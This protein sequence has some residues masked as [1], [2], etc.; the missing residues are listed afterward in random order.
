MTHRVA[1]WR[2]PSDRLVSREQAGFTL[3]ELIVSIGL[4]ALAVGVMFAT[5]G[6]GQSGFRTQL[7][8][9][10][11]QQRLRVAVSMLSGDLLMAGAGPER[12][13]IRGAF[14]RL[15][16]PIRP[17]RRGLRAAE[18][19]LAFATDRITIVRG[20]Q[21]RAQAGL[22]Q[23]MHSPGDVVRLDARGQGC[24]PVGAC[25]FQAGMRAAIFDPRVVGAGYDLFTVDRVSRDA[26]GHLPFAFSRPYGRLMTE[27]MEI[28]QRVYYHDARGR[29]LVR[30]DG[31]RSEAVVV[32]GVVGLA[33]DYYVDPRPDGVRA[34]AP[35]E[36]SCVY[37]AGDPPRPR[38]ID[39]GGTALR[40]LT[41]AQLTDGPVCGQAPNRFD[42]DLLRLRKVRVTIRVQV[43]DESLRGSDPRDFTDPGA[44][45]QAVHHVPDYTMTFEVA[46]R[47]LNVGRRG[48]P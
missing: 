45:R 43:A 7:A 32:D 29:R 6:R 37:G 27:V 30:Y 19:D 33:F 18:G 38:L 14:A 3:V 9:G 22:A 16:P 13:G 15:L 20:A 4:T 26:L 48:R 46:P 28:E 5:I 44:S 41:E 47:N 2:Q 36:T 17:A 8:I 31:N 21:S 11:Q 35:G 34:P 23:D 24:P 39:L 40:R 42:G 1:W 12:A 25:G 10:D